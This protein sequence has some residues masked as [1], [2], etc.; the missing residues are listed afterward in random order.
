MSTE[1]PLAHRVA[2]SQLYFDPLA[3]GREHLREHNLKRLAT[4]NFRLSK[5]LSDLFIPHWVVAVPLDAGPAL[6]R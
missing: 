4:I 1:A 6:E 5:M 2:L 3:Q